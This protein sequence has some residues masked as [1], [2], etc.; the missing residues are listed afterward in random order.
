MCLTRD[1]NED[2]E[3][4]LL[5][6]PSFDAQSRDLFADIVEYIYHHQSNNV[7]FERF[8]DTAL[9]YGDQDLSKYLNRN[10]LELNFHFTHETDGRLK[11]QYQAT[12][13]SL[14][15]DVFSL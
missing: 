5:L 15:V 2:T 7:R 6:S 12:T 4:C 14:I 8:F 11:S 3:H 10:M 9:L 13:N 1:G